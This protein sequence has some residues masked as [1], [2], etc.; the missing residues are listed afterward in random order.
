M[1]FLQRGFAWGNKRG[2]AVKQALPAFIIS[3]IA[4]IVS[5]LGGGGKVTKTE[6]MITFAPTL[7]VGGGK[8]SKPETMITFTAEL[9]LGSYP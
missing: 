4:F 3:L 7:L 9:A 2:F 1:G 8:V 6:T 5:L